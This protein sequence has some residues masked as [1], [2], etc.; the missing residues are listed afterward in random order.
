MYEIVNE[1]GIKVMLKENGILDVKLEPEKAHFIPPGFVAYDIKREGNQLLPSH[2]CVFQLADGITSLG[3]DSMLYLDYPSISNQMTKN[4]QIYKVTLVR[5]DHGRI[6]RLQI[7][8][9][10]HDWSSEEINQNLFEA[11]TE[12]INNIS[13]EYGIPLYFSAF[14]IL[15]DNLSCYSFIDKKPL[16]QRFEG[17]LL[18]PK[19]DFK[20]W[21]HASGS[22]RKATNA[23]DPMVKY[24]YYYIAVE[25]IRA[26]IKKE[27]GLD[28]QKE[29][30]IL[31]KNYREPKLEKTLSLNHAPER[32]NI[33]QGTE[34]YE[35]LFDKDS[36]FRKY[37]NMA[38]HT[39][40]KYDGDFRLTTNLNHY[41]DYSYG[42][43]Y[44]NEF[45]H[46]YLR[47]LVHLTMK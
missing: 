2:I 45:F 6:G 24:L 35:L 19:T 26:C 8:C 23:V 30:R 31:H 38:A 12:I 22:Y 40:S 1:P 9:T 36:D 34:I 11:G 3:N 37:R 44:L 27:L 16:F 17:V 4:G 33:N 20:L 21:H 13:L 25:S 43:T 46:I 18:E 47:D 10:N 5:N 28:P 29:G 39:I 41:L 14:V 32:F 42:A 15:H 7:E